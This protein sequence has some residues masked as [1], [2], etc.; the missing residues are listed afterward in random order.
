MSVNL[1]LR[2]LDMPLFM[3]KNIWRK[4]GYLPIKWREFPPKGWKPRIRYK[5]T[6]QPHWVRTNYGYLCIKVYQ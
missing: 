2:W 6:L 3:R 1:A 4:H 5:L